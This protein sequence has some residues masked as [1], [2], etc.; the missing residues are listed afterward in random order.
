MTTSTS[1]DVGSLISKVPG[2]LNG[3]PCIA[4]T[5]MPVRAVAAMY[6]DGMSAEEIRVAYEHLDLAGIY[7]AL[8]YYFANRA[9]V[10]ADLA[11]ER[12]A[13]EEGAAEQARRMAS[14][15]PS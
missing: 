7:A 8:A 10:D 12:R 11:D 9:E 14:G 3:A 4:G 15:H 6:N 2:I 13:Y 1:V 5:R